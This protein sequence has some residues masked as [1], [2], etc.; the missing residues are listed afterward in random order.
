MTSKHTTAK[1]EPASAKS[2]GQGRRRRGG[3]AS[4]TNSTNSSATSTN[5]SSNNLALAIKSPTALG[6]NFDVPDLYSDLPAVE[7]DDTFA[8]VSLD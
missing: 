2:K 5:S 4:S 7:L 6:K 1:H 8:Y 3:S